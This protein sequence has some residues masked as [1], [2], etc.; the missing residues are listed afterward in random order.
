MT[1]VKDYLGKEIHAE[2]TIVYPGRE[3]SNLWLSA[4]TVEHI[5]PDG[6]LD[7][8]T[9]SGR[10]VKLVRTDRVAVVERVLLNNVQLPVSVSSQ[11]EISSVNG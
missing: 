4:G 10:R 3:G 6:F 1:I 5:H 11:V 7:V 2:D 9:Q 8:I